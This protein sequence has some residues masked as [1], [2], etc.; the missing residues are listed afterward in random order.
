MIMKDDLFGLGNAQFYGIAGCGT[1]DAAIRKAREDG[2]EI[3]SFDF[4]TFWRAKELTG[5]DRSVIFS[6][7]QGVELGILEKIAQVA[8]SG[9]PLIVNSLQKVRGAAIKKCKIIGVNLTPHVCQPG[10]TDIAQLERIVKDY[11][12]EVRTVSYYLSN[13]RDIDELKEVLEIIRTSEVLSEAKIIDLGENDFGREEA[14]AYL[15]V[16]K[17]FR[18]RHGDH[19]E[20]RFG[21]H[22]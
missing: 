4:T 14:E 21:I 22:I 17:D 5:G 10:I 9:S 12:M 19:F 2:M 1:T 15:E 18:E 3:K 20:Y 6:C 16:L 11:D 8:E 13:Y 7:Q